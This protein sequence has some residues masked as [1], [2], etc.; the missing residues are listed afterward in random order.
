DPVYNTLVA[1][2]DSMV[3]AY[4]TLLV[5]KY[6]LAITGQLEPVTLKV[7]DSPDLPHGPYLIIKLLILGG[8]LV[9]GTTAG[10]G[11]ALLRSGM[12]PQILGLPVRELPAP[13]TTSWKA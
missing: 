3:L 12:L 11:L 2:K 5:R 4:Q 13:T 7:L 1:S 6:E 10:G 9:L 8:A